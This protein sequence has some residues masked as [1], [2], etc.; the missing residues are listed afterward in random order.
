MP[1]TKYENP[2]T[3]PEREPQGE[4]VACPECGVVLVNRKTARQHAR[5]HWGIAHGAYRPEDLK[6]E[7]RKR[8]LHLT[9]EVEE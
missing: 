1:A 3:A 8:Y 4:E 9:G 6:G 2:G 7:A 5:S